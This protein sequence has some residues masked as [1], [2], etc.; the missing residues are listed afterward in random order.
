[1]SAREVK[2]LAMSLVDRR[3]VD[4]APNRL[5]RGGRWALRHAGGLQLFVTIALV[6]SACGATAMTTPKA[7]HVAASTPPPTS[8]IGSA[9]L[10]GKISWSTE[11]QGPPV[12]IPGV[13][14]YW[15]L[16]DDVPGGLK[17]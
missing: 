10:H 15:C 14:W 11:L 16:D 13:R 1:M 17:S 5:P 7:R 12:G 9:Y 4:D 2:G 3:Q 8:F 6:A